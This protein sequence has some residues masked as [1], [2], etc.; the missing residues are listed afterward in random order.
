MLSFTP[1]VN[2]FGREY[3]AINLTQPL[4]ARDNVQKS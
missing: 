4:G 3:E 2:R 1:T